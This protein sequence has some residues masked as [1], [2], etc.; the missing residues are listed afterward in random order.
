LRLKYKDPGA[1]LLDLYAGNIAF[2]H[3]DPI[4][5]AG[6]LK[7]GKLRALATSA[8]DRLVSLPNIPSASDA[9]IGNSDIVAWWSVHTPKGTPLVIT[10]KLEALFNGIVIS[11]EHR[12]FLAP[13]G[14]DPFPGNSTR[15]RELLHRDIEAWREYAR[16]GHIEPN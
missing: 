6:P 4:Q 12:A 10:A 16:I 14:S 13:L 9:G 3:F 8:K 15:V 1:L 2:A 5:A 7:E 11:D